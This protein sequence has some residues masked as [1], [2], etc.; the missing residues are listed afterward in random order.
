MCD[1]AVDDFLSVLKFV[2]DWYI[3]SKMIKKLHSTLFSDDDILFFDE[4]SVNVTFFSDDIGILSVDLNS[5]NLDN[6]NFDVDNPEMIIHV[7]LMAWSNRLK[8][9]KKIL[10]NKLRTNSNSMVSN[11]M[12]GLV[13]DRR[14]EKRNK[15]SFYW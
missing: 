8:Q 5:V 12:V 1:K 2:P 4:E 14:W 3:T 9:Q 7:R 13:H 10:K 15:T 6:A 11:K